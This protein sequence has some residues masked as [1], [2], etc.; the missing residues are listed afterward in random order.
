MK[1]VIKTIMMLFVA[2]TFVL[3]SCT[4]DEDVKDVELT[5]IPAT[6][7]GSHFVSDTLSIRL[8]ATG[9]DD[10]KLKS[11]KITKAIA[12]TAG[13][14]TIYENTKLS[15]TAFIYDLKD[16]FQNNEVGVNTYTITL[17]GEKGN[18]Q[19]KTYTATV[20]AIGLI[21]STGSPVSLFGQTTGA[22]SQQFIS[23]T[24]FTTFT[25]SQAIATNNEA[26]KNSIDLAYYYGTT[27]NHS[28]SSLDDAVMHDRYTGPGIGSF[29]SSA[30]NKR[31]TG[32]YKVPAGAIA[33]NVIE[34][35]GSD[36]DLLI[37]AEGKTYSKTITKLATGDLILFKT[38]EGKIGLLKV[39]SATGDL[40]SNAVFSFDGLVQ[41]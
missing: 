28:I 17:T 41:K 32:L 29:W 9:N 36:K 39:S 7:S 20:R 21:E 5:M 3:T 26:L 13:V 14:I 10:N 11:I 8:N 24:S 15:G 38:N 19:T 4:D 37:Y 35:S 16:T 25:V 6:A 23:L 31:I 2:S 1:K 30:D 34:A 27:N 33:Y 22:E 18:A 40:A 12:G